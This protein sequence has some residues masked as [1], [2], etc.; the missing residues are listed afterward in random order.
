M[1]GKVAVAE[2]TDEKGKKIQ[3]FPASD[4][5][6]TVKYIFFPSGFCKL[7]QRVS[8]EDSPL[9]DTV[10]IYIIWSSVSKM[11]S[12]HTHVIG[13]EFLTNSRQNIK[14]NIPGKK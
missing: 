7:S 14:A 3:Q 11:C 1:Q 5:S 12:L 2:G 10:R 4:F 13:Q 6:R 9:W 8:N